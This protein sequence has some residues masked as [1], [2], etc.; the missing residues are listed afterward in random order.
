MRSPVGGKLYPTSPPNRD[1]D[2]GKRSSDSFLLRG[3][4]IC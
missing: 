3:V 2:V 4:V 1:N